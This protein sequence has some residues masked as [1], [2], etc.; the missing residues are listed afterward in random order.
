MPVL[1]MTTAML[2]LLTQPLSEPF[3]VR[4]LTAIALCGATC[5]CLGAYVVLRRM[6]S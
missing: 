5:A 1:A 6:A 2:E 3:F 4:A